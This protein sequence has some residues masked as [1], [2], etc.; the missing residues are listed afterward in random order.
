MK[1]TIVSAWVKTSRKLYGDDLVERA[2]NSVGWSRDRIFLPTEEI[3]DSYPKDYFN[4][5]AKELSK[6]TDD[7][8]YEVGLDNIVT[9]SQAFPAF[10]QQENLYSF[11]KSMYDIHVVMTKRLPGAKPPLVALEPIS[12][13]AAILTYQ[14]SRA[15]FG[16]FQGMLAG[17]AK[18]FQEDI[19]TEVLEKTSDKIVLKIVFPQRIY[20]V[21]E[22]SLNKLL[23]FGSMRSLNLKIAMLTFALTLIPI[24]GFSFLDGWTGNLLTALGSGIAAYLAAVLLLKPAESVKKALD[25]LVNHRYYLDSKIIS[26]DLWEDLYGDIKN[27]MNQVKTDFVGFKGVVDEMNNFSNDFGNLAE[28]MGYTSADISGA[29]EHVAVAATSQAT[30]TEEA[31]FIL[32][33]NVAALKY[34]VE[35]ENQ[36]KEQLEQVVNDIKQS[37]AD[38]RES[39]YKLQESL[40]KFGLVKDNAYELQEKAQSINEITGLVAAIADQTKLL[41]LNANIEAARAGE[42]GRGF[43]IVAEEVR[44]LSEESKNYSDS[45][46]N[47]LKVLVGVITHLVEQIDFQY[48][49]L[50]EESKKMEYVV[51]KNAPVVE[52]IRT[53][54]DTM[55][56]MIN[57]LD[58]EMEQINKV[59]GKIESLAAI[60]QENS[61]ASEE[62]SASVFD[63]NAK[64]Q[65]MMD[66]IGEF[67]KVVGEFKEDLI[68]YKI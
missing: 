60:S 26:N 38:I 17:A 28:H 65:S 53:V 9:F 63:Y 32:N 46:S 27:Y 6:N 58:K 37:F 68:R 18:Y 16:Y 31:V 43:A 7:I 39:A 56:E 48:I 10:F 14:S 55:I 20:Y 3:E 30:E 8:L 67:K 11:L 5:L 1:G 49:L 13:Q 51:D 35:K 47:D 40:Q 12:E 22:Y 61:A 64:L 41:A 29:V 24:W 50:E 21:K 15:M 19:Q 4:F 23:S 52:H 59:F 42:E 2:M 45:I 36:G 25:D 54:A 33:D 44:K 34:I 62:M 57:S 66:K